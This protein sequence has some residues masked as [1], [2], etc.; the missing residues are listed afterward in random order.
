MSRPHHGAWVLVIAVL[1]SACTQ[2]PGAL[3]VDDPA[4]F[5]ALIGEAQSAGASDAQLEVLE[6]AQREGSLP[7]EDLETLVEEALGCFDAAGIEYVVLPPRYTYTGVLVPDFATYDNESMADGGEAVVFQCSLDSY[8]F[9][10][11]AYESQPA[12]QEAAH[13]QFLQKRD[14]LIDCLRTHG[15][16]VDDDATRAEVEG[17]LTEDGMSLV[18]NNESLTPCSVAVP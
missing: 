16:S 4:D 2:D 1:T 13:D 12:V 5:A 15:Y 9:A 6:R 8:V 17:F 18:F 3:P 14:A 11:A 7:F 10:F